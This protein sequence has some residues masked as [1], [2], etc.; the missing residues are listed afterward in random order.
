VVRIVTCRDGAVLRS[1]FARTRGVWSFGLGSMFLFGFNLVLACGGTSQTVR[2]RAAPMAVTAPPVI[3]APA[4]PGAEPSGARS[5]TR[6]RGIRGTLNH[7]DIHQ[8]MDAR[9]DA[10]SACIDVRQRRMRWLDGKMR[11]KFK[12][13]A[14]GKPL[15]VRTVGSDVGHGDLEACLLSVLAETQFPVPAGR[16]TT[17]DFA[18]EMSVDPAHRPADVLDPKVVEKVR[19]KKTRDVYKECELRRFRNRYTVTLYVGPGGR[20]ISEGGFV[21]RGGKR[22]QEGLECVLQELHRWRFARV[23]RRSKVTFRLR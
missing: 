18:W 17:R 21:T 14:E 15:H 3:A 7:D 1:V 2:P 22:A 12:V 9:R 8:T 13:D 11:F 16:T 4:E 6:I 19:R 10:L 23:K 20:V 5:S